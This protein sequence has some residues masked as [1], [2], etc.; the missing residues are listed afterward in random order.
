VCMQTIPRRRKAE[1]ARARQRP[2]PRAK[3]RSDERAA[4]RVPVLSFGY[5]RLLAT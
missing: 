1:K 2:P 4:R 5:Y 3:R